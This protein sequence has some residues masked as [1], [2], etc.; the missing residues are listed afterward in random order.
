MIQENEKVDLNKIYCELIEIKCDVKSICSKVDDHDKTLDGNG[1][2]GLKDR[3][4]ALENFKA[5]C[6]FVFTPIAVVILSGIGYGLISII[7]QGD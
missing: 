5:V 6:L 3:M 1:Q 7:K 4:S 2:K